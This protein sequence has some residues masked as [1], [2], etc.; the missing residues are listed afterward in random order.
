[1]RI[2]LID[3]PFKTFTGFV[4]SY[5]PIGLGYLAAVLKEANH[6]VT[7][8]DVDALEKGNDIDFKFFRN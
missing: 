5:Y 3:P 8:F 1:M 6:Q 4:N 2:L 7:I